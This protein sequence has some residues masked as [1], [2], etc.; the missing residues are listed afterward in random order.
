MATITTTA[1][2]GGRGF[3]SLA[4]RI[5]VVSRVARPGV[6]KNRRLIELGEHIPPSRR[7]RF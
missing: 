7:W 1:L 3:Y 4:T 5:G 2:L 6:S